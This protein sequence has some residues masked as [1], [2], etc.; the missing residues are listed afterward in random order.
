MFVGWR[1]NDY[2]LLNGKGCWMII[3]VTDEIRLSI[4]FF[5]SFFSLFCFFLCRVSD[6]C[7]SCLSPC[8]SVYV[9]LYFLWLSL[10]ITLYFQISAK[11]FLI[12]SSNV[13]IN[14]NVLPYLSNHV[15]RRM[16]MFLLCIQ[17]CVGGIGRDLK[18]IL[19]DLIWSPEELKGK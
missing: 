4:K 18:M 16:K 13:K 5:I 15:K 8:V 14:V 2:W 11:I 7:S 1:E 9:C 3:M 19:L 10:W 17:R 12:R 6:C